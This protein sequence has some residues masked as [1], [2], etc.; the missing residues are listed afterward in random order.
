[1]LFYPSSMT[2]WF[3]HW[4]LIQE[5]GLTYSKV[6]GGKLKTGPQTLCW[7]LRLAAN[8]L[9]NMSF[10]LQDAGKPGYAVWLTVCF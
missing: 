6:C 7:L 8:N 9:I 10:L 4:C 2:L 5:T 1:M 3:E